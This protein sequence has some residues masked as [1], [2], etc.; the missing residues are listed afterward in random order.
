MLSCLGL[1]AMAAEGTLDPAVFGSM[2]RLLADIQTRASRNL[3]QSEDFQITPTGAD[4]PI[5]TLLRAR[6]TIP[7]DYE[8]C[9]PKSDPPAARVPNLFPRYQLS[10][11]VALD[12]ALDPE[13][14]KKLASLDVKVNDS[15][16]IEFTV[17][18]AKL[19]TVSDTDLRRAFA[20]PECAALLRSQETWLVRGYVRGQRTFLLKNVDTKQVQGGLAHFFNFKVDAGPG[21]RSVDLSDTEETAFLQIVSAVVPGPGREVALASPAAPPASAPPP[22]PQP[23]IDLA[24]MT[25]EELDRWLRENPPAP[26]AGRAT[27]EVVSFVSGKVQRAEDLNPTL[28][29]FDKLQQALVG[30]LQ[31]RLVADALLPKTAEIRYFH[32]ADLRTASE[33]LGV[34]RRTQPAA[35][36]V[37][38]RLDAP[39]DQYEVWMPRRLR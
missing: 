24:R 37:R 39:R 18:G 19:Q 26:A 17:K 27:R 30:G 10:R 32:D 22:A 15:D 2:D 25:P 5:G 20:R 7:I 11:G 6:T 21:T 36:L 38:V 35:R 16:T 33:L 23:P 8:A 13:L 29:N 31:M 3:G 1:P 9:K 34:L 14:L 4:Y 12:F 28:Q